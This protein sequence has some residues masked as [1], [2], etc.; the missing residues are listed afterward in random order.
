MNWGMDVRELDYDL[1]EDRIATAPAEPRDAARLLVLRR[2]SRAIEHC[3]VRDL[4]DLG[5]LQ[6]GDLMVVNQ[7]RV[8]RAWFEGT[9]R[10]TAGRVRGL[11]LSGDPEGGH[12]W[13]VMLESR[14]S[15]QRGE[16]V[17]LSDGT[18]LELR[19]RV[20]AGT[21]RV[22]PSDGDALA[23]LERVGQM[24]LPP[25]IRR[26]RRQHQEDEVNDADAERYNTVYATD[27]GSVAAPTAG[28]H[29]TPALMQR[30]E[31]LGVGRVAVTLHVGAGTFAPIRA[32]RLE[33][34]VMHAERI[35][36]SAQALDA[37]RRTR[38][39][40]RRIFVVGTTTVRTLESLPQPLPA[41]A[42][43]YAGSTS[44]FIK[45]G[46]AFRFTD[47]LL[48]NFHLPR[49]TLLAMVAALPGVGMDE[50]KQV[51]GTAVAAG[52]RFYSYGDAML[53]V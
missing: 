11:Y 30:I 4:P 49:S 41:A 53:V 27:P 10:G 43:G 18:V 5:V 19:E 23:V 47:A 7:T 46:F 37:I 16:F 36:V 2:A 50:L 22:L 13:T 15:L 38:A 25:Y 12:A 35:T 21:W 3:W 32:D 44:L 31:A 1:P 6:A 45:P 20:Q 26:Q 48:T 42:E 17:E 14:G 33:D 28:L 9:R 34:H 52:Y 24:P 8:I 40:G 39:A 51:Y 29:F